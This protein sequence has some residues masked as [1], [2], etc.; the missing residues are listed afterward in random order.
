[1]S[2]GTNAFF[3]P[4]TVAVSSETTIAPCGL[5]YALELADWS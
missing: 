1:M 2:K 4:V 3:F 5:G